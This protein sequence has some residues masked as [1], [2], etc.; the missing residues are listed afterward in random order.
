[1]ERVSRDELCMQIAQLVA[2]RGTCTRA[3]VGAVIA[4]EGRV[5]ATGYNG[6]P[7]GFPHCTDPG[8]CTDADR[9]SSLG[10]VSAV[11]AEAN[12]IAYAARYGIATQ[13]AN[14][15]CSHL[16]CRKCA[17]L[18]INAG[19]STLFYA[20]DYRMKDGWLLLQQA[21]IGMIKL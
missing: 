20:V 7:S 17:E 15:Y 13:G 5:L 2:N 10:C 1:M 3:Q 6:P 12:A 9:A 18:I 16:P 8:G 21:G 11:H 14:L 4:R 19:I